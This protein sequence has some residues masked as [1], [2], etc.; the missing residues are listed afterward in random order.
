MAVNNKPSTIVFYS[1]MGVSIHETRGKLRAGVNAVSVGGFV[2][3]RRKR[4][5]TF[6]TSPRSSRGEV[7]AKRRV[8][9]EALRCQ[10]KNLS[11]RKAFNAI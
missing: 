3:V 9:G 5:P 2:I 1:E 8:R 7:G 6:S 10:I 4:A 11:G